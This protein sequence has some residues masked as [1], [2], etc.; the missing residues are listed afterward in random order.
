[1]LNVT[2]I[3][4]AGQAQSY[5]EQDNYYSQE[6][7]YEKSYWGGQGA[8]IA[9]LHGHVKAEEFKDMLE[10]RIGGQEL[11]RDRIND[12]T[13]LMEREHRPGWD[14]TFSAPKSVSI[15][16]EIGG[17]ER[18]R[19]VHESAVQKA[20]T[21]IER[22]GAF[23]RV[24]GEREQTGNLVW[25]AFSH[26]TSRALDPQ[27][28]THVVT[29]NATVSPGA[30][31]WRSLSN[32]ELYNL[33]KSTDAIYQNEMA[34]G[35]Q[36]LGYQVEWS[37]RSFE[38]GGVSREQIET[39]SKRSE[40]IRDA[41]AELG[42]TRGTASA[43]AREVAALDTRDSKREADRGELRKVWHDEAKAAGID[44]D[45]TIQRAKDP[46]S[47]QQAEKINPEV[48]VKKAIAHLG[49]REHVFERRDL[50]EWSNRFAEGKASSDQIRGA[51]F[52]AQ[53][54][55]KLIEANGKWTTPDAIRAELRTLDLVEAG[56]GQM[57][58]LAT[59]EKA[60]MHISEW[61]KSYGRELNAGQRAAAES[62]MTGTDRVI[63]IQGHAGVGKTTMLSAVKYAAEKTDTQLIGIAPTTEASKVMGGELGIE[64]NTVAKFLSDHSPER[65]NAEQ[66]R[67]V[68]GIERSMDIMNKQHTAAWD[69]QIAGEQRAADR[70]DRGADRPDFIGGALGHD[71]QGNMYVSTADGW[72]QADIGD[73][74]VAAGVKA[75]EH[76][77]QAGKEV[78][79][80]LFEA[81]KAEIG[82]AGLQFSQSMEREKLEG[83]RDRA[84]NATSR[85]ERMGVERDFLKY[86]SGKLEKAAKG[87]REGAWN[88]RDNSPKTPMSMA[89]AE[90]WQGVSESHK[91]LM[92]ESMKSAHDGLMNRVA[93]MKGRIGELNKELDG[94]KENKLVAVDEASLLSSKDANRIMEVA[95]REGM[96]VAF[97]GDVRQLPAVEAG[98]PFENAKE[99]G[100]LSKAEM[101][102]IQRQKT[103]LGKDVVAEVYKGNLAAAY[104]R[105]VDGGKVHVGQSGEDTR[106]KLAEDLSKGTREQREQ[107]LVMTASRADRDAINQSVRDAYKQLGD[108]AKDGTTVESWRSRGLTDAQ[109]TQ[110]G[111]YHKGDGVEFGM[112]N[113]NLDIK[114]G[115]RGQITGK[116]TVANTLNVRLESG[117]EVQFD[118]KEARG[119][120]TYERRQIEVAQGDKIRFSKN[121]QATGRTN[122]E[123]G[124]VRELNG[125]EAKVEFRGADGKNYTDTVD[126]SRVKHMDHG[127]AM[128]VHSSQGKTV[129]QENVSALYVNPDN[130][131]LAMGQRSF[132]VAATRG[133]DAPNV[134]THPKQEQLRDAGEKV[135]TKELANAAV[136]EILRPQDKSSAIRE[137][138]LDK[139][140][141]LVNHKSAGQDRGKH[142]EPQKSIQG[143]KESRK[144]H[145][146]QISKAANAKQGEAG[147][148]ATLDSSTQQPRTHGGG[149][150]SQQLAQSSQEKGSDGK[151][152]QPSKIKDQEK[153]GGASQPEKQQGNAHALSS[154]GH[155]R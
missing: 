141:E 28:H 116:D 13:G 123:I 12:K 68:A 137:V 18:L 53:R 61:E 42:L 2:P 72:R 43:G 22:E 144:D 41:L 129:S 132:T 120:D 94:A 111:Q 89:G 143:Q 45:G 59:S 131:N 85:H 67:L 118:P 30:G 155:S 153:T 1:M 49:E 52:D 148:T 73:V 114:A 62:I 37:G 40:Q 102:E 66:Q 70:L 47:R 55:G 27:T 32:E 69:R 125:H 82:R 56:R 86:Q 79:A 31:E 90:R 106:Q 147:K 136:K 88:A 80:T 92:R 115:E 154:G 17:D 48:T 7:G 99:F 35:A 97:Q 63:G 100:G 65:A 152:A 101:T 149:Q 4:S 128:T 38:I 145:E 122:G 95:Q 77:A 103:D 36:D 26:D 126:M 83:F 29:M 6:Q 104:D 105:L 110:A 112:T 19:A 25:A 150:Q 98:K 119:L 75:A 8:D 109:K 124:H 140:K 142:V 107:S 93:E 46:E 138:G 151:Q 113:K 20:M 60:Q 11:G 91:G 33:Q 23:T 15:F 5:F 14:L 76:L 139:A 146:T 134:Y 135:E 71:K 34:R 117:R 51:I 130:P 84:M 54:E 121:D 87:L 39:F 16:S 133:Q 21:Y 24:N 74:F 127:Y 96:R 57:Q 64:T 50:V 44:I 9:G 3:S 81:A 108:V 58:P 78:A 10:G